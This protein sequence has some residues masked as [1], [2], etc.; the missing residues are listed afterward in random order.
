M[1]GS[2]VAFMGLVFREIRDDPGPRTRWSVPSRLM[3]GASM[4]GA[5]TGE[6]G[7]TRKSTSVNILACSSFMIRWTFI[8]LE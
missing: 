1:A 4:R 5:G 6:V 8:D 2:P 7:V 3:Y